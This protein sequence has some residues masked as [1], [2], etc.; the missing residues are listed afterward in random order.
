MIRPRM[1]VLSTDVIIKI[2]EE[3]VAVLAD[4]GV[5]VE[6]Q[7]G[8]L[9]IEQAGGTVDRDNNTARVSEEFNQK[10]NRFDSFKIRLI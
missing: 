7:K 3:A 4:P 1:D 6:N 8:L 9:L 5:R 10:D 2:Y